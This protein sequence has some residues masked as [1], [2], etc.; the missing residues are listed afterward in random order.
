[1]S[2]KTKGTIVLIVVVVGII[3][4]VKGIRNQEDKDYAL[5]I[6]QN[7]TFDNYS[8]IT[9]ERLLR[10]NCTG[11]EWSNIGKFKDDSQYAGCYYVIYYGDIAY[12]AD[13][14]RVGVELAIDIDIGRVVDAEF[15]LEGQR[16]TNEQVQQLIQAMMY[17]YE[18]NSK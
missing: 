16:L 7:T 17:Y 6:A 10:A 14:P 13:H 9:L 5:S 11:G 3:F 12:D 4:F 2:R 8:N 1:M 18:G 15:F